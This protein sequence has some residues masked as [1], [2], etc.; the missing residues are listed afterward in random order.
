MAAQSVIIPLAHVT[1]A[2]GEPAV[3]QLAGRR[4]VCSRNGVHKLGGGY[5]GLCRKQAVV[6][7]EI[8]AVRLDLKQRGARNNP[9]DVL[10]PDVFVF[11]RVNFRR[12]GSLLERG[13]GLLRR[14]G[15]L[16][17]LGLLHGGGLRAQGDQRDAE[18]NETKDGNYFVVFHR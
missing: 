8:L 7:V 16:E 15:V 6:R 5:D 4:R 11:V 13:Q 12:V 10:R 18:V 3:T 17:I 1:H 2:G 14:R 9:Q